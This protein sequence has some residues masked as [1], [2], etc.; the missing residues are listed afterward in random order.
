ML[1]TNMI[2]AKVPVKISEVRKKGLE[3]LGVT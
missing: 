1:R 2:K 3:L